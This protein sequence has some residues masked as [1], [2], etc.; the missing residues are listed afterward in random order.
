MRSSDLKS[1]N[2][3]KHVYEISR[4]LTQLPD[5]NKVLKEIVRHVITGLKYDRA[6]IFLLNEDE[7]LLE[8][9]CISGFTKN[10]EKRAWEHPLKMSVHDCYETKVIK[11]GKPLF[12]PDMGRARMTNIDKIIA[13]YQE[14][15]SFLHVPLKV[16]DKVLGTIGV[17]RYRTQMNITPKEVKDL[18]IFANQAAIIIENARLYK[19]LREQRILSEK[20]IES[21]INGVLVCNVHGKIIHINPK[22]EE[23][24]GVENN[25][26]VKLNFFD[27]LKVKYACNL[28]S[29]ISKSHFEIEYQKKESEKKLILD[30]LIFPLQQADN[31]LSNAV[32]IITDLTEKRV[33]D[34]HLIRMEKFAALGSMIT[35]LAHEIRN[36]LA[37]IFTTVQNIESKMT[38]SLNKLALQ[39]VTLE[40]DRIER[41]IRELLT[42][43]NPNPLPL[44]VENVNIMDLLNR[45][46]FFVKK[47]TDDKHVNFDLKGE[48]V[49]IQ[50]DP[51][52]LMQVFLNILI[53]AVDAI[54]IKGKININVHGGIDNGSYRFVTI[55]FRDNGTGI[56]A[57]IKSKIFDPFFT[58][59][60]TGTGLGLTVSHKIIQDHRGLIEV[61]SNEKHGTNV[62]VKLPMFMDESLL[63]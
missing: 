24:L 14:R 56:N 12:I 6:I 13:K 30:L 7:T 35:G 38:C 8:C 19:E 51:N 43:M 39:N 58:T 11:K 4:L 31:F 17:D 28:E 44:Q 63:E 1:G 42:A 10:G 40:L 59:K 53:N 9:R 54:R 37:S 32:V 49:I 47:K 18:T 33:M 20:I 23:I 27:I 52:R 26:A 25:P 36:P 2:L 3:L 46:L 21:Y 15:K 60:S 55:E 57:A 48:K 34:E 61:E 29:L 16:K 22:A 45:A 5:L 41:L 50:A 62:I